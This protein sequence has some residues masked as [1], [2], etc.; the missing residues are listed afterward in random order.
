[1]ETKESILP[2]KSIAREVLTRFYQKSGER[3]SFYLVE[4]VLRNGEV[5]TIVL[6]GFASEKEFRVLGNGKL[7][8]LHPSEVPSPASFLPNKEGF[9]F[10]APLMDQVKVSL[11]TLV[12]RY[13]QEVIV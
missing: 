6:I 1:M 8:Q 2:H 11:Q 10:F 12:S 3:L 13:G 7:Y 4:E 9:V 5:V